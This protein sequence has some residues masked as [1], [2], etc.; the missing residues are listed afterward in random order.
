VAASAVSPIAAAGKIAK[1]SE[2]LALV[3][4]ATPESAP[5]AKASAA[6][7]RAAEYLLPAALGM[8]LWFLFTL[9]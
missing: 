4:G 5:V 8:A 2:A 9:R 7:R 1:P 6:W 3:P